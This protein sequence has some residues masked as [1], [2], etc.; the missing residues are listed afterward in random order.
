MLFATNCALFTLK[1]CL[2]YCF[3]ICI[4]TDVINFSLLKAFSV[5]GVWLTLFV[6]LFVY[7]VTLNVYTADHRS[8][9]LVVT[10][11]A[12]AKDVQHHVAKELA[13]PST[14]YKLYEVKSS[15]GIIH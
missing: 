5:Y 1:R 8:C 6:C 7:S 15:G 3:E 14:D 11:A 12:C 10:R 13:L 9:Q 4:S 2:L